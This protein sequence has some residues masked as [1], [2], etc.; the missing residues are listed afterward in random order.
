MA[1]SG[2]CAYCGRHA[3]ALYTCKAC[4]SRCCP[5][6]VDPKSGFCKLCGGIRR[7]GRRGIGSIRK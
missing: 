2:V 5:N 6:C 1:V 7:I 3:L 4:G